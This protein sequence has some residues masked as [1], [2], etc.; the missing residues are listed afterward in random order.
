MAI[1][2][3]GTSHVQFIADNVD[4]DIRTLDGHGTFHGMGIVATV[5]PALAEMKTVRRKTVTMKDIT[6]VGRI[7]MRYFTS[8]HTG[9]LPLTYKELRAMEVSDPTNN[10]DI[11]WEVSFLMRPTRPA[12]SGVMQTVHQGEHPGKASVLF[13]P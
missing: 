3:T 4:H 12:W 11:L 9:K 7:D 5:T 13:F 2:K 6:Q 10:L 8:Q 1:P